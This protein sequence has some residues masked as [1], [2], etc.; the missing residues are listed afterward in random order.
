MNRKRNVF[1]VFTVEE[2]LP[3]PG[4]RIIKYRVD[5]KIIKFPRITLRTISART[6]RSKN[7][8]DAHVNAAVEKSDLIV[9]QE[10]GGRGSEKVPEVE[11]AM[12]SKAPNCVSR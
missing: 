2:L 7:Q 1:G 3:L 10:K 6:E 9:Q 5:D 4:Q 12:S 11:K 8:I